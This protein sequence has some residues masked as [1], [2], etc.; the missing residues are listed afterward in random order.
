MAHRA[1]TEPES[2]T[3]RPRPPRMSF[4]E[5][6]AWECEGVRAEWVDGE[7]RLMS[8]VTDQHD[9]LRILLVRLVGGF[10][11]ERDLGVVRSEPFVM[12]TGLALPGR[13]PDLLFVAKENLGRLR[14]THLEGPADL[15]VEIVSRESRRRDRREKLAEYEQGGVREYW[16]LDQPRQ[17]AEFYLL[18]TDGVYRRVE[19][20]NGIFRSGVLPGFWLRVEW[21]WQD[22]RP[23]VR[24]LLRELGVE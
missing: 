1:P 13:S 6:L 3:A 12:K 10:A 5:F 18:G 14:Q 19:P 21:L 16:L 23:R 22:P 20:V 4:E 11:E 2:R 24:A 15:V 8:A 9:E 7:V 17:A